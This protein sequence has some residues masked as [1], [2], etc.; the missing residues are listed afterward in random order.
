MTDTFPV[1]LHV[2]GQPIPQGSK[3]VSRSGHSYEANKKTRP[4]RAVVADCASHFRAQHPGIGLP[5]DGNIS[6]ELTFTFARPPSA[7]KRAYPNVKPD[8]DKLC[9]AIFDSLTGILI[10]DDCRVVSLKATKQYGEPG[11]HIALVGS[12]FVEKKKRATRV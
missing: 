9:R 8:I 7:K 11:V 2:P 4:W 10:V 5:L 3:Q 12:P 1:E 6:A